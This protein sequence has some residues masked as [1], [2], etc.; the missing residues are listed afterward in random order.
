M[1]STLQLVLALLAPGAPVPKDLAPVGPAPFA[2]KVVRGGDGVVRFSEL[3]RPNVDLNSSAIVPDDAEIEVG[4]L[5]GVTV[6][7]IDGQEVSIKE[8]I[9]KLAAG[10]SAVASSDGKKVDPEKRRDLKADTLIFVSRDLLPSAEQ[11]T[12]VQAPK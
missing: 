12:P 4:D 10:A 9:K 6:Y 3:P 1:N 7:G 5:K 11:R 8:A 2:V